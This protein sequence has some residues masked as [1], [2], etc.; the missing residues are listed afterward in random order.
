MYGIWRVRSFANK[1]EVGLKLLW[2]AAVSPGAAGN[3]FLRGA[4][5]AGPQILVSA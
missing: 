1:W 3:G 4:T 5:G 2:E